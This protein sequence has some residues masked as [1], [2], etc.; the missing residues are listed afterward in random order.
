[1]KRLCV[2][3]GLRYL[4]TRTTCSL[5]QQQQQQCLQVRFL[6]SLRVLPWIEPRPEPMASAMSLKLCSCQVLPPPHCASGGPTATRL[7]PGRVKGAPG[8]GHGFWATP[9]ESY[10]AGA[11][12]DVVLVLLNPGIPGTRPSLATGASTCRVHSTPSPR[13]SLLLLSMLVR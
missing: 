6:K 13:P 1:M 8:W 4:A 11:A 12:L 9:S 10:P 5:Q 7:L 2:A 3:G